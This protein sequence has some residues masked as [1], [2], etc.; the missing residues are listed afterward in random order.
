MLGVSK[1]RLTCIELRHIRPIQN[2]QIVISII[3]IYTRAWYAT[4]NAHY[5]AVKAKTKDKG[6]AQKMRKNLICQACR[7]AE[8][9]YLSDIKKHYLTLILNS[10]NYC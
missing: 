6:E 1:V 5:K 4:R 9:L 3:M 10:E 7:K 2:S 8:I